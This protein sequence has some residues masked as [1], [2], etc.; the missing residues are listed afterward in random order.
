[1]AKTP[2]EAPET[3]VLS[4][5]KPRPV[6]AADLTQPNQE[7]P[8]GLEPEPE[9]VPLE[10][11]LIEEPTEELEPEEVVEEPT[12]D[13]LKDTKAELTRT[14]QEVAKLKKTLDVLAAEKEFG[15]GAARQMPPAD[16][17]PPEFF[18]PEYLPNELPDKDPN[19]PQKYTNRRL[20]A[21][22]WVTNYERTKEEANN[23]A[24]QNPDWPEM[25]PLM[26]EI[27]AEEPGRYEGRGALRSLYKRAK[28]RKEAREAREKLQELEAQAIQTGVQ[29]G[30]QSKGRG[31]VPPR[32][33][34]GGGMPA[35]KGK[36]PADFYNWTSE[37]QDKW[38]RANGYFRE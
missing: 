20:A 3:V 15:Q 8:T 10:Q 30:K 19:W 23:F 33:G 4:E 16:M 34:S 18:S 21:E 9:S 1:M 7:L 31:V 35:T 17:P 25:F 5:G 38:L 12:H 13:P 37:A 36:Y 14:Q 24:D 29:M 28:E 11:P 27:Q 32:G 26:K 2:E 6:N 22:R